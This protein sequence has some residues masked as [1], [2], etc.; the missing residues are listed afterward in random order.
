MFSNEF[1]PK[2]AKFWYQGRMYDWNTP[3]LHTMTHALHY[4]SSVFE[5]I[6]AYKTPEGPA[7]FRLE[8]HLDR[9]LRSAEV[10]YMKVPYTKDKIRDVLMEVMRENKLESAYIRPLLFHSYGNLG[11][12]PKASPVEMV[13]AVWE[14]G[15]YLGEKAETGVQVCIIPWRRVHHSQYDMA[16][17]LGGIYVMST[18]GG[19][20]ARR[21]GYDEAVYLN[22][23]ENIAEGPGENILVVHKGVLKT[24]DRSCSIL[25]GITRTSI[26][27]IARD[28]RIPTEIGPITKSEFFSADEAFFTGTAAE[29]TPIIKVADRS[30]R[31]AEAKEYTIGQG[32]V[33]P[34]TQKLKSIYMDTVHGRLSRYRNWLAYVNT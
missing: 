30:N 3:H 12:V 11:L 15:P 34:I 29:V 8:E 6:R 31:N 14:W 33:G 7:V 21:Q 9:F 5:G 17:K 1:F 22:I 24:N 18:I 28:Q 32:R 19:I 20:M 4:G 25:E 26:L 23:E 13:V 27:E 2:A 10:L 16:A